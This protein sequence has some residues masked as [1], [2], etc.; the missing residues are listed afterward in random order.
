MCRTSSKRLGAHL[1][2]SSTCNERLFEHCSV[3]LRV[4]FLPILP[5]LHALQEVARRSISAAGLPGAIER[6]AAAAVEEASAL[7]LVVD[8]QASRRCAAA[9]FVLLAWLL[10]VST[11]PCTT[12]HSASTACKAQLILL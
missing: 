7:I 10:M 8:G 2:C 6:Q 12:E 3:C 4:H 11:L 5:A 1:P 9:A